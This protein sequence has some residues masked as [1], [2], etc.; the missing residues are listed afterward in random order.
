MQGIVE[1]LDEQL[2]YI[3]HTLESSILKI[4]VASKRT[5]GS[6]I[7][8]GVESISVHSVYE[9][10]LQ[11]LPIQGKKVTLIINR[12][13]YFCLNKEC[14]KK[15]FAEQFDFFKG[16]ERKTLRLQEAIL[17]VSLTQSSLSASKYLRRNVADVGKSTLCNMLKKRDQN[18]GKG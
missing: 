15:T 1:L 9:R 12:R 4:R 3:E 11:D 16:N 17:E 13:K 2:Q 6:C 18:N 8:C 14:S 5:S 7:Y 10:R